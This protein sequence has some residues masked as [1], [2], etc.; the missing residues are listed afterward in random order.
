[1]TSVLPNTKERM[2]MLPA[3]VPRDAVIV[4]RNLQREYVTRIAAAL[5]RPA[6]TLPTVSTTGSQTLNCRVTAVWKASTI[7]QATGTGS[8]SKGRPGGRGLKASSSPGGSTPGH[9]SR[10]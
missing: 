5:I 8:R 1:M 10:W 7:S 9:S 2:A 6:A 3:D 4:T